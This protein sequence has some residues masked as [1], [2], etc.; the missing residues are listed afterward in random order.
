MVTARQGSYGRDVNTAPLQPAKLPGFK[1][2]P[3]RHL[4]EFFHPSQCAYYILL[5]RR[6]T[7]A[8]PR[9]RVLFVQ[10]LDDFLAACQ[11]LRAR[12]QPQ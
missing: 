12:Q 11:Q 1:V 4:G 3:K 2:V 10:Y 7:P 9:E 8:A 5:G 6:G